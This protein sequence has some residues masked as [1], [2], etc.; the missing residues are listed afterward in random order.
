MKNGRKSFILTFDSIAST[1]H[2]IK[3]VLSIKKKFYLA[4]VTITEYDPNYTNP[5]RRQQQSNDFLRCRSAAVHGQ[6]EDYHQ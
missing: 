6:W 3:W 4:G 1:Q 5:D 2:F